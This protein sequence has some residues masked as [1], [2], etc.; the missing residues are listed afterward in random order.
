MHIQKYSEGKDKPDA[1]AF[2]SSTTAGTR[3]RVKMLV[4]GCMM[5]H[6][7]INWQEPA[8]M[9]DHKPLEYIHLVMKHVLGI[10]I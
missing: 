3:Y 8:C 9:N 10:K 5:F 2:K 4:V 7:Y 6:Q 1:Y